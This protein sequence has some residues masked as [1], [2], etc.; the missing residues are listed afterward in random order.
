[1]TIT[2]PQKL[3]MSGLKVTKNQREVSALYSNGL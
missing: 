2:I 1:M 3:E